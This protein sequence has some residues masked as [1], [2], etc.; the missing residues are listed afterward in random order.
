MV[1]EAVGAINAPPEQRMEPFNPCGIQRA[2]NPGVVYLHRG[3]PRSFS[4]VI[5]L[6]RSCGCKLIKKR[7]SHST[8]PYI[9]GPKTGVLLTGINSIFSS[10]SPPMSCQ[11]GARTRPVGAHAVRPTFLDRHAVRPT[12][13]R[14]AIRERS[15]TD[16]RSQ[17]SGEGHHHLRAHVPIGAMA[18]RSRCA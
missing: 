5:R 3:N 14:P 2:R 8:G 16:L 1:C 6:P 18:G 11:D 10:F 7:Y 15:D 9:Q 13:R 17:A 12:F 4:L